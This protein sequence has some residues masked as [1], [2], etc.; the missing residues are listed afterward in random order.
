MEK[1]KPLLK[2]KDKVEHQ[3]RHSARKVKNSFI[4]L[5][6]TTAPLREDH[7]ALLDQLIR[8]GL[9]ESGQ[10]SLYRRALESPRSAVDN[11]QLR[12]SLAEATARIVAL[13][14]EDRELFLRLRTLLERRS[15][16][17]VHEGV[18]PVVEA[19]RLRTE[20]RDPEANIRPNKTDIRRK[21]HPRKTESSGP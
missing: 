14:L 9:G 15:H 7:S 16:R 2:Q 1:E 11:P 3:P 8:S 18:D 21:R 17:P 4:D 20:S 12:H 5:E 6:P 10:I 13:V 19:M